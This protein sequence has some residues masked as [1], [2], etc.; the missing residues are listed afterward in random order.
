[1]PILT[2]QES[3]LELLQK[4][5]QKEKKGKE[6]LLEMI[7]SVELSESVYNSNAIENSTLTH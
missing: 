7:D 3:Y 4:E 5:Y 2:E 6:S 1:M